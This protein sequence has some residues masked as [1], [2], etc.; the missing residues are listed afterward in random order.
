MTQK[1]QSSGANA[2]EGDE[3]EIAPRPLFGR[4]ISMIT[5]PIKSG[6]YKR[7]HPRAPKSWQQ[8]VFSPSRLM[9]RHRS[10]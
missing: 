7:K 1:T 10:A 3:P 9:R 2:G 4:R 8:L 6:S 5:L